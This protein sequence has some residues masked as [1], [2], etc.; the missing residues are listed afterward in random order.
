MKYL[1][2]FGNINNPWK[3]W[4]YYGTN[5]ACRRWLVKEGCPQV[6]VE[7]WMSKARVFG[8]VTLGTVQ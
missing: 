7:D 4:F 3:A 2:V 5:A 6:D 8:E 1:Y